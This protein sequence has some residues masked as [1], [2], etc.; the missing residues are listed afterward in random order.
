MRRFKSW[1]DSSALLKEVSVRVDRYLMHAIKW[2]EEDGRSGEQRVMPDVPRP[3][4]HLQC[5]PVACLK[6]QQAAIPNST[7]AALCWLR[8][9]EKGYKQKAEPPGRMPAAAAAIATAAAA[10]SES[11]TSSA[12]SSAPSSSQDSEPSSTQNST[13]SSSQR[14]TLN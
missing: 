3:C 2:A 14:S 10:A 4:G 6:L 5:H 13:V 11:S 1:C 12:A 9:T 7:F 8:A